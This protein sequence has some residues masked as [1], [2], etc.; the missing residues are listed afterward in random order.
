MLIVA[1]AAPPA[2]AQTP[3]TSPDA[4][5][6]RPVVRGTVRDSLGIPVH[7]ASVMLNPGA[8]ILRTDT[9]GRFTSLRAPL[10]TV[11]IRIRRLG[12]APIDT[13]V[14]AHAGV[15]LTLDLTMRRIPQPLGEVVVRADRVRQC[16]RYSLDGVLCRREVGRGQFLNRDDIVGSDAIYP[17][18][19]LRDRPGFRRSLR[20]DLR[21]VESTVGWRC[22]TTL[23]DGRPPSEMNP[24]PLLPEMFAVE[25]Y[26]PAE[27]PPEYQ[28]WVWGGMFPCTLVVFWSER[29]VRQEIERA[30]GLPWGLTLD[31]TAGGFVMGGGDYARRSGV[32]LVTFLGNRS[33]VDPRRSNVFGVSLAL[34]GDPGSE[35]ACDL[36]IDAGCRDE[37]PLLL[38][39][40]AER[41][42]RREALVSS[43]RFGA[44]AYMN[45]KDAGGSAI[46]VQGQVDLAASFALLALRAVVLPNLHGRPV[47]LFS[48]TTGVR[49]N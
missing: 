39:L 48:L 35:T 19:V 32:A 20:G 34:L 3:V 23:V 47:A 21:G 37:L 13:Q 14:T 7:G 1:A 25:V 29:A 8:L 36:P 16:P 10:G 45:L 49:W 28:S 17:W 22:I 27:A 26:Q 31:L 44:G 40:G 30:S 11:G 6:L 33:P 15:V 18:H 46:G 5:S 41:G 43:V 38:G 4:D 9:A 12:F 42:W 2:R 24:L